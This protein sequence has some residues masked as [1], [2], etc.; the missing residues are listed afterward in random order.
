GGELARDAQEQGALAVVAAGVHD[1]GMPGSP[2]Q[3]GGLL[4]R[5]GVHVGAQG[6]AAAALSSFAPGGDAG[7]VLEDACLPAGFLELGEDEVA[8]A[9]LLAGELRVLVDPVAQ[10]HA[11]RDDAGVDGHQ[12]PPWVA[13]AATESSPASMGTSPEA[14]MRSG[15]KYCRG[16]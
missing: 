15:R 14:R 11:A 5:Q 4:Q 12:P 13:G 6:D 2:G 8:G 10:L 3:A 9:D 1:V 7:A 16:S